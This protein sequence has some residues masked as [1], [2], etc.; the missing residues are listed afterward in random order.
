[1]QILIASAKIMNGST[2]LPVPATSLPLFRDAARRFAQEL[3]RWSAEELAR[4]LKCSGVIAAENRLRYSRFLDA[5]GELPAVLAY[6]GQAYKY[7]RA[8]DFGAAD[9][10]FAQ[11][12][13]L[14]TSFL[15]GLLRPLDLIHPYRL[16]GKVALEAGGGVT[17]FEY[18]RGKLT[19]VLIDAVKG[20]DGVLVHLAT[21]EMEHLFDW[22]RV[23][24]EVRVVHPLFYA[25]QGVG[26]RAVSV[27]AKSCRGAMARM[28]IR[29]RIERESGLAAFELNG[30]RY[31]PGYGDDRHPHFIKEG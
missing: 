26:L 12:H 15:Y 27:H 7:L 9:F 17:M 22:R 18:W 13:L 14:I 4:A 20:D 3:G 8:D 6:Y 24:R 16:E 19:D 2:S 1:M 11:D 10:R 23:E 28:I 5:D 21:E 25:D 30:Y 31:R 29:E